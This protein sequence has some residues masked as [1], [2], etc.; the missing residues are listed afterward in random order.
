[1]NVC[2]IYQ[3]LLNRH[4][5]LMGSRVNMSGYQNL[6]QMHDSSQYKTAC[7]FTKHSCYLL[8]AQQS[9]K[10]FAISLQSSFM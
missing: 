10:N 8:S 6:T 7:S 2:L 1:M 4:C 5:L 9:A 3:N